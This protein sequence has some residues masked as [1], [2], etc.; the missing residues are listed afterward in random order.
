MLFV[1]IMQVVSWLFLPVGY[2]IDKLEAVLPSNLI[3]Q[4][5]KV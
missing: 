2:V 3:Q 4:L 1:V 5:S